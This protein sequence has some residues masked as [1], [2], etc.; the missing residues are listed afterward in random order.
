MNQLTACPSLSSLTRLSLRRLRQSTLLALVAT[1][2]VVAGCSDEEPAGAAG[3]AG[4]EQ[5]GAAGNGSSGTTSAG[6]AGTTAAGN[7]GTTAAGNAGTTSAGNGG[8][9]GDEAG[10]EGGTAGT[11]QGGEGGT[12]GTEQG[13]EGGEAGTASGG[14]AGTANGG[15]A[16][17]TGG[18]AG[19]AGSSANDSGFR[20]DVNG[21]NFENYGKD[22][23]ATNLTVQGMRKLFGDKVCGSMAGGNCTLTPPA[24]KWLESQNEGMDGGHC[25]G[26]AALSILLYKQQG[27]VTPSAFGAATTAELTLDNNTALQS[28]IATWFVT[29][30]TNPTA[31]GE[32]GKQ[33]T[34]KEVIAKLQQTWAA[35]ETATMGIYKPGY[36]DGHAITPYRIVDKGGGKLSVLVYDNNFPK[37]EREVAVDTDA[38]TWTYTGGINPDVPEELYQ[39]DATTFTLSI[40]PTKGRLTTQDC[41]FCLGDSG[42]Q[43][44]GA[45][46]NELRLIGEGDLLITD[47]NGKKLGYQAGK[48]VNQ[49][50]GASFI[51]LMSDGSAL[52]L[53]DPEPVYKVPVNNALSIALTGADLTSMSQSAL[54]I[55]GPGYVMDIDGIALDPKQT[56]TIT[57]S[58]AADQ[59]TYATQGDETPDLSFGFESSGADYLFSVKADGDASGIKVTLRLDQAKG[60]FSYRVEGAPNY[61]IFM[62]RLDDSGEVVFSHAG[63]ANVS[64][65]TTYVPYSMWGG[66][67]KPLTLK[68]DHLSDGSIDETVQ[69]TDE[70]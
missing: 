14:T 29:Q 22:K 19:T 67:G 33:N 70:N 48:L 50:T 18:S 21:F 35:G 13:G 23:G 41:D 1:S 44:P 59:V 9:A 43:A 8:A 65:D 40:T 47:E 69:A 11:E 64:T 24:Q 49:I 16:G 30:A 3:S 38:N 28:E 6:N 63:E 55:T 34:P 5:A 2:V 54:T 61:T 25:E 27:G 12:A 57:L 45:G 26:M 56:D 39:G 52:N 31:A 42:S 60:E 53:D 10:G 17:T 15:T 68:I 36:K 66:N 20:A 46:F 58:K 32:F 7:A 62:S 37:Q 51:S 4:S